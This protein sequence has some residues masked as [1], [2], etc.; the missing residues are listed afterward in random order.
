MSL[1]SQTL[2]ISNHLK[3]GAHSMFSFF[4]A[5]MAASISQASAS[6]LDQAAIKSMAGCFEVSFNFKETFTSPEATT[7]SADYHEKGLEWVA[8]DLDSKKEIHLQH[9]LLT[10]GGPLKHWRQE[11]ALEGREALDFKGQFGGVFTWDKKDLGK[12]PRGHWVQRVFQVDDSPRYECR[13]PFVRWSNVEYWECQTWAPLPRREFSK[14]SDYNVLARRNRQFLNTDGWV[15]EQDNDKL[16]VATDG[17]SQL[18]ASEKGI[19]TY[20]RVEDSRCAEAA[21]WWNQNKNVWHDIQ[22]TWK[23][24]FADNATIPL[25]G[26]VDGQPLWMR[27]FELADS[28]AGRGTYNR[29]QLV[30]EAKDQILLHFAQ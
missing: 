23:Q 12:S 26:S 18:I 21:A 5:L 1:N 13:A 11:W 19:D 7:R 17:S 24:V 22:A 8:L 15:H 2:A 4:V 25:K 3:R 14:R 29:G 27:L 6:R 30:Q 9:I 10:P 28:T 16:A 20:T